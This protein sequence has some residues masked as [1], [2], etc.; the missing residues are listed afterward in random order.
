MSAAA[1]AAGA[2]VTVTLAVTNTGA[3]YAGDF[4]AVAFLARADA[5]PAAEEWPAQW[6]PR[7]GFRKLHGVAPGADAGATL[8]LVARDFARWDAAAHAFTVR[9]GAY[10]VTARGGAAG[11]SATIVVSP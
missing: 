3:V 6:L 7:D 8:T 4:A 2:N 9:A 5:P 11:G 10:A 1:L